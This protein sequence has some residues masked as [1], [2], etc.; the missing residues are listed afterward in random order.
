MNRP[1]VASPHTFI[2][3]VTV[4][5]RAGKT[6]SIS[7]H[8]LQGSSGMLKLEYPDK[9]AANAARAQ[10]LKSHHTHKVGTNTLLQAI[11]EALVE[12]APKAPDTPSEEEDQTP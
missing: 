7:F 12:A 6:I 10:L 2:G 11:H 1:R 3:P 9:A 5:K 8:L 4:E